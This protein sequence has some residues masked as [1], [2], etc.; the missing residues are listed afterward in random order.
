MRININFKDF[1]KNHSKKNIRLYLNLQN[2]KTIIELK[3]Y[4]NFF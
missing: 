1:K 3:I 4:L 2:V